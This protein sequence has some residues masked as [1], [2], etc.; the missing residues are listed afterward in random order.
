M[1]VAGDFNG[2]SADATPLSSED[3]GYW[4]TDVAGAHDGQQYKY[5]VRTSDGLRRRNDP[6]PAR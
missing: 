4:S 6:T 3:N 1:S 5:V 2:W